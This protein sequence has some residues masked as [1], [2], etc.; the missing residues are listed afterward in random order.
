[1]K[2]IAII[3]Y[4]F[5]N[6]KS[7]INAVAYCGAEPAV[8]NLPKDIVKYSGAILP[9]VGAFGP[10]VHFLKKLDFDKAILDYTAAGK[11]LYGTCLGFQLLF[12]K[13]YE[14]GEYDGLNIIEGEVKRFDFDGNDLKI[15]HMGWNNVCYK[16]DVNTKKMF[17]GIKNN[18]QFYFV[19]SYYAELKNSRQAAAFTEY[20]FDFC[21]AIA[22]DNIWG[23]QFHPEK[24]GDCGLRLMKNFIGACA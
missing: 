8:I 11:M 21:S 5:G 6:V 17:G 3:D 1:M 23:S 18:E 2:K 24:S 7:V 4:G 14:N 16:D 20:G 10:A 9:G 12:T 15:P 19:H 22:L 13:S